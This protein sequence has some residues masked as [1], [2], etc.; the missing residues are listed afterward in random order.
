MQRI[1]LVRFCLHPAHLALLAQRLQL[2]L[3]PVLY[4]PDVLHGQAVPEVHPTEHLPMEVGEQP[5]LRLLYK[6]FY[7]VL[8]P[9]PLEL[10]RHQ[11]VARHHRLDGRLPVGPDQRTPPR[12]LRLELGRVLFLFVVAGRDRVVGYVDVDDF[13]LPQL[14][15]RKL[16]DLCQH[17]IITTEIT[18]DA[19]V[20]V[21]ALGLRRQMAPQIPTTTH[22]ILPTPQNLQNFNKKINI[23]GH[24]HETNQNKNSLWG[25]L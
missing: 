21:A 11:L 17:T 20:T 9:E 16:V 22:S 24:R 19:A 5:P 15:G 4:C 25:Q 23:N 6:T 12:L 10:H 13:A 18:E 1:Y 14:V 7:A 3:R 2:L 8:Q